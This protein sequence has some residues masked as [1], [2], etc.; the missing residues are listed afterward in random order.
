MTNKNS[1]NNSIPISQVGNFT[2]NAVKNFEKN[3]VS[4]HN[5]LEKTQNKLY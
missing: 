5:Y 4:Q 1:K 3:I 2:K